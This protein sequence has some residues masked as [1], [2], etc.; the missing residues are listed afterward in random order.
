MAPARRYHLSGQS[1]VT[2]GGRDY[3]LGPHD[4]PESIARYAVLISIYQA[5][6]LTLPDGFDAA[7]LDVQAAT[8]LGQLSPQVAAAD[9]A[10][11]PKLVRHITA[12]YREHTAEKYANTPQ[13]KHRNDRLCDQLDA[14]FGDLP[15]DE[16]GPLKLKA[17]R[18]DRIAEGLARKYVNRLTNCVI[19]VFSHAVSCEMVDIE[20]VAQLKT[21]EP[22]RYGQT[23]APE[24][25]KVTPVSLDV[26]RKTA[27]H[28]SPIVRAMLR[29]QIAT[30]MRPKELC[31]MRPIDIDRT[32]AVWLYRPS[33]HKT[34]HTGKTKVLPL[35]GDAREAITDY[36]QRD[37]QAFCFSPI[38]AMAWRHAVGASKRVTPPNQ[39]NRPGTNVKANPKSKPRDRYDAV[40][41]RQAITRAA[42]AAKV[43]HW[44]PYQCRHLTATMVRAALRIEDAQALLGHSTPL[45]TAHYAQ[46]SIE[47]ATRAAKAAPTL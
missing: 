40:S 11:Q 29:I 6:G 3:Y 43:P 30:G 33:S 1:V 47:A 34:A 13:E 44:F 21:L 26:V 23:T 22:L 18:A 5:N 35:I 27:E 9:Q 24:T 7:S 28:L 41:Y 32:G 46:E 14:K 37:P 2:I 25:K 42:N 4:S 20:K 38:E 16:F 39:G 19:G 45:M 10:K 36:L 31:M 17:F 12:A 15:I 8:L